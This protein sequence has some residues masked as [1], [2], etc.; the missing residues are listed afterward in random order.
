MNQPTIEQVQKG[1]QKLSGMQL[2]GQKTYRYEEEKDLE[3]VIWGIPIITYLK[4]IVHAA[5]LVLCFLALVTL[6]FSMIRL[7]WYLITG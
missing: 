5:F 7:C 3:L 4:I 1:C 2:I 6:S